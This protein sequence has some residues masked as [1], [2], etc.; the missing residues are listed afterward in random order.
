MS[1]DNT[2]KTIKIQVIITIGNETQK[3]EYT[4]EANAFTSD[5]TKPLG[6]QQISQEDNPPSVASKSRRQSNSH[7]SKL[8]TA[9]QIDFIKKLA[10][11]NNVQVQDMLEP[12]NV[13]DIS[14]LK[15]GEANEIFDKYKRK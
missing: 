4:D 7:S 15:Q 3:T 5:E 14:E 8:V 12:Y 6:C 10:A 13:S 2:T 11:W 1:E 9:K